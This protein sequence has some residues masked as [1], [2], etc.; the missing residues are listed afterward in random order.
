METWTVKRQTDHTWLELQH[1]QLIKAFTCLSKFS[2]Q[3]LLVSKTSTSYWS[4]SNKEEGIQ[5][6]VVTHSS[7]SLSVTPRAQVCLFSPVLCGAEEGHPGVEA[8]FVR[9]GGEVHG[10]RE[11]GE[12]QLQQLSPAKTTQ[13]THTHVHGWNPTR[14]VQ[15]YYRYPTKVQLH[16]VARSLVDKIAIAVAPIKKKKPNP[17]LLRSWM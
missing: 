16:E 13:K 8:P 12:E 4:T 17:Y 1:G 11:T 9:G 10:F 14:P 5:L 15:D 3:N 2:L 7:V 6:R